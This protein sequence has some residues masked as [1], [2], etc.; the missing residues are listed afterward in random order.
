MHH[1][2]R[3]G[4]WP[5]LDLG[6]A[7]D[8]FQIN[9]SNVIFPPW[10]FHDTWPHADCRYAACPGLAG[11]SCT[12]LILADSDR[13]V[14]EIS[15]KFSKYLE[16][17]PITALRIF[18]P[19]WASS[20]YCPTFAKIRWQLYVDSEQH[21]LNILRWISL[22]LLQDLVNALF[23]FTWRSQ[24][25]AA[26]GAAAGDPYVSTAATAAAGEP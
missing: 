7:R 22:I 6:P 11:P 24:A 23:M 13:A 17:P 10:H 2:Q 9:V 4:Q 18:V 16:R 14:N 3:P 20:K 8:Q 12:Y 25:G 26:T 5:G 21:C 15:R 1:L 19:V